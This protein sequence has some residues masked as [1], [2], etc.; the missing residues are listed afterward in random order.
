LWATKDVTLAGTAVMEIQKSGTNF[1]K[2]AIDGM[3]NVTYGGTLDIVATG[4]PLAAGDSI[5]LF[6]SAVHNGSF[7]N[8]TPATPGAGLAWSF[9]NGVL[10]VVS[11]VNT[12][13]T[14]L[15]SSFIGGTNLNLS[16]PS[17][18]IGWKL[19]A[20]TN[21]LNV[22]LSTNW[23]VVP[24]SELTNQVDIPVSPANPAVFY[25]MVYP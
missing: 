10:S 12:T 4:D 20:Q 1:T 9:T 15:V 25:R 14:N 7:A 6:L 19:E 13:P 3:T 16:W 17:D 23:V 22:G 11:T 5:P 2:D 18:H 24:G 8:I 21:T